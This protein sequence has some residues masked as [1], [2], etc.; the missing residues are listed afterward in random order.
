MCVMSAERESVSINTAADMYDLGRDAIRDAVNKGHL[1][2][3]RVGRAIRIRV[4]DLR[5]WFDGLD[6]VSS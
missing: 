3:K 5:E 6:D 2:A 4:I 1:P